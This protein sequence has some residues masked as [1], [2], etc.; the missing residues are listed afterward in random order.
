MNCAWKELLSILPPWLRSEADNFGKDSLQEIRLRRG[1]TVILT[2][3]HGRTV[4]NHI[5][6]EKDIQYVFSMSCRY[7]PWTVAS[8]AQG[9]ITIAG[10]HRIGLC[11]GAILRNG[12]MV[13]INP[14]TSLNIRIAREFPGI[15]GNLWLLK[16]SVLIIGPPGSGK[17]TLLRDLV[18]QRSRRENISVVDQRGELFPDTAGF[19]KGENTDVITGCDK[20]NGIETVLRVMSPQCIALDEITATEDCDALIQAGKCGVSLLAT[21]HASSPEDLLERP[22]YRRLC[23]NHLFEHVVTLQMDKSWRTERMI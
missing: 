18:R 17:T 22:I 6:E 23:Q 21:A 15:C 16:H 3:S 11:G 19:D 14:I 9:F 4:L 12:K 10:G 13:G 20:T 8:I 5:V 7:S 1:E 2:R